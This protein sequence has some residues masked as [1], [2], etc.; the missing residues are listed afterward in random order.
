MSRVQIEPQLLRWASER[1]QIDAVELAL[2]FPQLRAW[3]SGERRPT[4]KQLEAF[5]KATHTPLGFLFLPEPPVESL[6]IKDLRTVR[7]APRRPSPDLLDTIYAMQRRQDW[8]Q[9][10]RLEEGAPDLG[11]VGSAQLS[12]DPGAV[13]REMRR[14]TG[15]GDGWAANARRWEDAVA[16]LRERIENL[17]VMAVINGIVGN[18]THRKLDV[19]E[20]RGLLWSTPWPRSSSSTARTPGPP[21]C[22]RSRTN[23]LMS[24]SAGKERESPDSRGSSPVMD[25]SNSSAT[26]P[27][28][29]SSCRNGN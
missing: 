18:N 12:D 17:G 19:E 27:Q 28:R 3:E 4:F 14:V 9:G 22:S 8:L 5:A 20:F 7:E 10:E 11:F 15:L 13:G 24:G 6:P 29:S 1:S 23:S 16:K 21:R 25:V 26:V 2:R